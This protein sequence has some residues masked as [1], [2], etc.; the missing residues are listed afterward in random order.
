MKSLQ[1]LSAYEGG[2]LKTDRKAGRVMATDK[3]KKSKEN[4]RGP[5]AGVGTKCRMDSYMGSPLYQVDHQDI[6]YLFYLSILL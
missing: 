3:G 4:V 1:T 6:P 5:Q 2:H